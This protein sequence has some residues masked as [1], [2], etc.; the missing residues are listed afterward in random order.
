MR[1]FNPETGEDGRPSTNVIS[2]QEEHYGSPKDLAGNDPLYYITY[3]GAISYIDYFRNSMLPE[4]EYIKNMSG[5]P[6]KVQ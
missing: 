3:T 2:S 1:E 4:V 5:F 6:T